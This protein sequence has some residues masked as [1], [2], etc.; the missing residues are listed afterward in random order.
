ML[1]TTVSNGLFVSKFLL[2]V[3]EKLRFFK[4]VFILF[5]YY[6]AISSFLTKES[7]VILG[8]ISISLLTV[9]F[10]KIGINLGGALILL[11]NFYKVP[12][13][14]NSP[15]NIFKLKVD[16]IGSKLFFNLSKS[17]NVPLNVTIG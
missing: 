17:L 9:S 5:V 6:F 4:I 8:N 3:K 10:L 16:L 2:T 1:G 12:S 14:F 11:F 15:Y 7:S 13:S